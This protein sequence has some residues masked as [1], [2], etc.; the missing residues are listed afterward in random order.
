M[1]RKYKF[2][3]PDGLYFIT[4]SVVKW[5]DV[6]TRDEY[7]EIILDSFRYC[8]KEKGLVIH[9]YV[10]MT[11]HLHLIISR[12]GKYLME[13]IMRDMKK[14]TS[15]TLINAIKNHPSESR[16]EWMIEI[17]RE[18]GRKN[19]NNTVYQFWQQDNHPIEL[20][21]NKM[22]D[23]KLNYIHENPVKQGF[24][25]K[26]EDYLWSSMSDYLGEA[27]LIDIELIE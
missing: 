23:Q 11:N 24:V 20:T 1:S 2:H 3:D 22:M 18:A 15:G 8:Q 12:R 17:F 7:R 9:A 25:K 4:Y 14:F 13:N 6:F 27:S 16:K 19:S 26:T 5:I 10:I 21:S